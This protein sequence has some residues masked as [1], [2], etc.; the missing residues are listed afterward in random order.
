MKTNHN[1]SKAFNKVILAFLCLMSDDGGCC[2][3]DHAESCSTLEQCG[4]KLGSAVPRDEGTKVY[5]SIYV[6]ILGIS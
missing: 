4:G 1:S 6:F 3:G 2:A 5:L